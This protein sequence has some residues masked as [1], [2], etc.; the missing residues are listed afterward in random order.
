M[1]KELVTFRCDGELE[2]ATLELSVERQRA[3]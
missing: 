1:R 2:Q 3:D